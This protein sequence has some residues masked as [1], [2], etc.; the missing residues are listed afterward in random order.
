MATKTRAKGDGSIYKNAQGLWT[1]SLELPSENGKR[2]RKVFRNKDRGTVIKQLR[3]FKAQL[4]E[5]GDMPTASWRAD[6]WFMHWLDDIAPRLD[7]RP[8]TLAGYR[9][10][11]VGFAIPELGSLPLEKI[12]PAHIRKVHDRVLNTPKPKGLREKPQEEWPDDVVMLS[13]TY[14]LNVHNAMS[15]ALKTAVSDGILRS[16]PCDRAARPRPRKAEQKALSLEEAIQLLAYCTTI[17]DGPLWATYLLTGARRGEILG[18]ERDRVQDL[19][20]LSWQLQRIPNLKRDAAADYE[21]RHLNGSLYL[22]RPKSSKGWRI[23][24]LVEPLKSIMGLAVQAAEDELVFTRNGQAWDPD[25]AT[26]RWKE[27]LAGAGLPDDIVLHGSRHTTADLLYAAG[28]PED[29]IMDIL[30]HSVRSV[31][32]GYRTRT[33]I[34]RLTDAMT[35]LSKQLTA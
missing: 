3:E 34:K 27:V 10:G 31:T 12:T 28:V 18:L 30:G 13:S 25:A 29:L 15:A 33:D 4:A 9:S 5:V 24:P 7:T 23:I 1:C 19:L 26:D 20:D 6:K 14:A 32:R 35:K 22:T 8:K 21:Y 16:N 2:R 11:L 17:E